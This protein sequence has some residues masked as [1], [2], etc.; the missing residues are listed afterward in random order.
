MYL[1]KAIIIGRM[2]ADPELRTTG[3]GQSVVSV[4]VATNR[5]WTNREGERQ[6]D[7]QFHNV[8]VW[9]RQAEVVNQFLKKGSLVMIEGRLQTRTWQDN[10]GQNRRTTEIV[11]ERVQFGPRSTADGSFDTSRAPTGKKKQEDSGGEN[12]I[13][14][15]NLNE[16][17]EEISGKDVPF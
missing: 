5:I 6:E 11:A 17:G 1:N 10:Q 16:E 3:S 4:S 13:P 7:T 15:I 14:E 12:N 2:T 9:G 8:V